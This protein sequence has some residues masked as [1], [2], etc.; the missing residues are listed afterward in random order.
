MNNWIFMDTMSMRVI[1]KRRERRD[2][3]VSSMIKRYVWGS[4]GV[5]GLEE[6]FDFL[7]CRCGQVLLVSL[8]FLFLCL[9][10]YYRLFVPFHFLLRYDELNCFVEF[11]L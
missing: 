5:H 10:N 6:D 3:S 4:L 7:S 2:E 11:G 8:Q 1:L 9:F